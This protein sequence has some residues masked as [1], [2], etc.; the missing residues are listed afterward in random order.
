MIE[1][2]FANNLL[3]LVQILWTLLITALIGNVIANDAGAASSAKAAVNFTLFVAVLS[4]IASLYGLVS[5]FVTAIAIPVVLLGLDC[6]AVL[7]TFISGVV[8]AAK[9]KAVNC[10][11]LVRCL[12]PNH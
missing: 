1:P 4:W 8:L 3:R 2:N 6:V 12:L 9:L 7:F 11:N 5:N 10:A